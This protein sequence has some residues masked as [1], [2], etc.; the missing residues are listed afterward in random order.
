MVLSHPL[1]PRLDGSF[2]QPSLGTP[3][4][5]PK[6]L[7]Q[8]LQ[9]PVKKFSRIPA[10]PHRPS[11]DS[12]WS[13]DVINEWN[14]EFSPSK[15]LI[16]RQLDRS[17]VKPLVFPIS[18]PEKK[19]VA[20]RKTKKAFSEKKHAIA[21]TFLAEI[22]QALTDGRISSLAAS[23]G[24]IKIIW[25]KKLNTTAGRASWK[26]ETV[27]NLRAVE[28]GVLPLTHRHH[29]TI[30]LADKVIDDEDRLLNV[31]AHE[32]C[33]LA[34]FMI[35]NVKTNPHGREFKQ[36]ASKCSRHFGHRGIEVT[37]KHSYA[38]DYKYVWSC[39]DCA[40]E[41]KRHSKSIDPARQRCGKCK[42][43]LV[44]MKPIRRNGEVKITG[45]QLFVKTNMSKVRA[46][47]PGS[48]QKDIMG[49]LGKRYQ[50][51]RAISDNKE[52]KSDT[53]EALNMKF[54]EGKEEDEKE[55]SED[56]GLIMVGKRLGFLDLRSL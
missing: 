8:N 31:I 43:H 24:G 19:D 6:I 20:N 2:R 30:E 27:R 49:L 13:Q 53:K 50:E 12:F 54:I 40:L 52:S 28:G 35:S 37:T 1:E 36:W 46:E 38:I 22:D 48:P 25:S 9:S 42:G 4:D 29:A 33:H 51:S 14:D 18:S 39:D 55:Q 16:S 34:T 45:Y 56:E 10:T 15:Q 47:N 23:T 5:S 7:P 11:M 26:L 32:F 3:D 44:Q 17:N 21:E 41:Y